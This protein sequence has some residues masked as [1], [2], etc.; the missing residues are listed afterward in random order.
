MYIG[1][2]QC[3]L[4]DINQGTIYPNNAATIYCDQAGI[5]EAGRY[6]VLE[7]VRAGYSDN[8]FYMRKTCFDGS[9]F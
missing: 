8:H 4:F 2:S 3:S 7:H 9:N 6:T 1:E 5:Q